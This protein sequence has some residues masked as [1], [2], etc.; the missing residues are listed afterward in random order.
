MCIFHVFLLTITK[1]HKKSNI[2][3][4]NDYYCGNVTI[5]LTFTYLNI[6]FGNKIN[7]QIDKICVLSIQ[8]SNK[9]NCND[10]SKFSI[11][12]NMFLYSTTKSLKGGS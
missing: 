7:E 9:S 5:T 4:S 12:V 3:F 1:F 8:Y 10:F 2:Y 6:I 11:L